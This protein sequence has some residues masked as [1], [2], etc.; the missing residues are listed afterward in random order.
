MKHG[1]PPKHGFTSIDHTAADI[2]LSSAFS[3]SGNRI[4]LCSADHRIRVYDAGS[5]DDWDLVDQWRGHDG[6]VL[7]ASSP[8]DSA[9][10]SMT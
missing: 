9:P 4:V 5:N 3:P 7:D 10:R 6:E 8:N 2:I 1:S